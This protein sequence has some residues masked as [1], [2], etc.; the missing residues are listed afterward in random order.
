MDETIYENVQPS[1]QSIMNV[2]EIGHEKS[3]EDIFDYIKMEPITF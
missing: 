2:D 1:E 3:M